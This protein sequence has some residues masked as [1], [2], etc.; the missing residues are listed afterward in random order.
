MEKTG[1]CCYS[2]LPFDTCLSSG[3][4]MFTLLNSEAMVDFFHMITTYL[5]WNNPSKTH[6]DIDS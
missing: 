6:F 3:L 4:A 5:C 1:K 2:D